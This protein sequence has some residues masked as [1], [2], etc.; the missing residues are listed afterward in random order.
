MSS[1]AGKQKEMS[2]VSMAVP[3]K[4]LNA[5]GRKRVFDLKDRSLFIYRIAL[6]TGG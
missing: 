6:L 2:S 1:A 4:T 5:M 3:M